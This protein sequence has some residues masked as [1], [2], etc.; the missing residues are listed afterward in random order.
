MRQHGGRG[1]AA[2]CRHRRGRRLG[3]DIARLAGKFWAHV[4]DD[5][6]VSRYIV[7][8]LGDI[9]AELAHATAAGGA[10]AGAV[11]FGLMHNLLAR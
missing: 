4:A 5:L 6:E 9:F 8:D 3:D 11:G 1:A 10:D 2:R 7:E